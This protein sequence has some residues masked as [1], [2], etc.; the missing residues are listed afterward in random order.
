MKGIVFT[1]LV[2]GI[3][4]SLFYLN[5]K[6]NQTDEQFAQFILKYRKSYFSKQD[7]ETRKLIF[8]ENLETISILNRDSQ[9]AWFEI[10]EFADISP[11]EFSAK[12]LNYKR[13]SARS[14]QDQILGDTVQPIDWW[15][16]AFVSDIK[17]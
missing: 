3:C 7:F 4:S 8:A 5:S 15:E 1:I 6:T 14:I 17:D 13:T 10:N 12:W 11:E 9:S 2:I 16:K